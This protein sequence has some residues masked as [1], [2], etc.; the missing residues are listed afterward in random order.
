LAFDDA[1]PDLDQIQPRSGGEVDLDL[2]LGSEPGLHLG[3][4][5]GGVVV[6]DQA[7]DAWSWICAEDGSS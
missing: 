1:E 7:A 2:G 5:V 4:F 6:H 3:M